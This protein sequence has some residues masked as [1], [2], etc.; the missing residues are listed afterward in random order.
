MYI[1]VLYGVLALFAA[2]D[3]IRHSRVTKSAGILICIALL[4]FFAVRF[5]LGPDTGQYELMFTYADDIIEMVKS[6]EV[7]RNQLFIII[8]WGL[9]HLVKTYPMYVLVLNCVSLLIFAAVVRKYSKSYLL[10]ALIFVGGG[11][12]EVYYSSGVRQ[13]LAMMIF[14]YAFY[15]HLRRKEYFWYAVFCLL[16]ALIHDTALFGLPLIPLHIFRHSI[17]KHKYIWAGCACAAAAACFIVVGRILPGVPEEAMPA[18]L[19]HFSIY[20]QQQSFSI[21]GIGMQ[22]VFLLMTGI[23]YWWA[24]SSKLK[25]FD[26]FQ[27]IVIVFG[28]IFYMAVCMYPQASRI[29]DMWQMV[30]VILLPALFEA[31]EDWRKKAAGVLAVILLH[32]Y[33]LYADMSFKISRLNKFYDADMILADYPYITVFETE[34]C[35]AWSVVEE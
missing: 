27:V 12:L 4:V 10:S 1:F 5:N 8:T 13:C 3:I 18:F 26:H 9:R 15:N 2:A 31:I 16:A 19:R 21:M 25:D 33:L 23:L 22:G 7:K 20:F 11:L 24:D 32:G 30:F 35:E 17:M 28:F 6:L 34:K 14:F 29:T